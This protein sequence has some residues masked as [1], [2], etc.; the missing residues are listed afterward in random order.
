MSET[1]SKQICLFRT[2]PIIADA[3]YTGTVKTVLKNIGSGDIVLQR[4]ASY[5][6]LVP[7]YIF[8]GFICEAKEEMTFFDDDPEVDRVLER[9]VLDEEAA[10]ERE[11][12]ANGFGSTGATGLA[13]PSGESVEMGQSE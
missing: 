5:V 4:D 3:D 8:D 13:P 12:G 1:C 2:R 11:R 10:L 7:T 6:Q 9:Y